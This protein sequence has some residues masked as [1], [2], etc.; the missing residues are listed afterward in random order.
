MDPTPELYKFLGVSLFTKDSTANR[1]CDSATYL[2]NV[3]D[4]KLCATKL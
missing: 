2:T 1:C 4:S 3:H